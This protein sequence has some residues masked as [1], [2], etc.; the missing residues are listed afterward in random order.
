MNQMCPLYV[1]AVLCQ[2]KGRN[3]ADQREDTRITQTD[4]YTGFMAVA[5]SWASVSF[6]VGS[7]FLFSSSVSLFLDKNVYL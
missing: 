3:N 1:E 6:Y 5:G 4:S 2:S 7:W